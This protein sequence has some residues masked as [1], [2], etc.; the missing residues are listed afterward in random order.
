MDER[1]WDQMASHYETEI[2]SALASDRDGV[3]AERFN[4]HT[5]RGDTV[6]DFGCGV[7]RFVPLAACR[8]KKV[9]AV[10]FSQDLL[11]VAQGEHG[12]VKNVEFQRR[13]LT[14]GRP[15]ICKAD[16]GLCVNVLIMPERERRDAILAN[17]RRNLQPGGLLLLVTPSLETALL[18]YHRIIE[19]HLREGDSYRDAARSA[20]ESARDEVASIAEGIFKIQGTPTKHFLREEAHLML[21]EHRF[22]PIET[23]KIQ[24]AWQDDL[25]DA[26]RWMQQ[27]YPWE[28]LFVARR[29]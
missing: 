26:P 18:T 19:W 16:V 24:Y 20:A 23:V 12:Q 14:A 13:D 2:F 21:H 11:D 3:F 25:A 22:E 29:V 6:C 8:A 9:Y 10:D 27:P 1:F 4:K 5:R 7:G 28:W 17:V 15:R